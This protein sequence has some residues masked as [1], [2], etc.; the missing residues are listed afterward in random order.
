MTACAQC[1]GFPRSEWSVLDAAGRALLQRSALCQAFDQGQTIFAQ[2]D[3]CCGIHC[4]ASGTVIL[5]RRPV[6][7]DALVLSIRH[8]GHTLGYRSFFARESHSSSAEAATPCQVCFVEQPA[9]D[10]LINSQPALALA[11]LR[12]VASDLRSAE[13]ARVVSQRAVRCRLAAL[14]LSLR[15][16]Y[17]CVD[18]DGTL[19]VKLPICR[20][21]LAASIAARPE[22]VARA[23]T[24]LVRDGVLEVDR[25]TLRIT[26]LDA[27]FDELSASGAL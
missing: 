7:G 23:L 14:I 20:R 24:Q 10:A 12:R 17:G 21:D 16:E 25:R 8:A 27:L 11:F 26:D 6:C 2:G 19:V 5:R 18:D 3:P 15:H 22:S 4:V 9:V 1:D 13:D